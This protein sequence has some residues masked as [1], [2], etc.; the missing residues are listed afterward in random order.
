[1]FKDTSANHLNHPQ[2]DTTA[3]EKDMIYDCQKCD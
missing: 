3:I 2:K 1:M